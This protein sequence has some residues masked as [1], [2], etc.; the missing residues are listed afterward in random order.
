MHINKLTFTAAM[1][2]TMTLSGVPAL[3]VGA[4]NSHANAQATGAGTQAADHVAA[5]ETRLVDAKLKACQNRETAINNIM[6]RIAT[7]GQKQ[8]DLFTTIAT[9]VETFYTTKGKT[10]SSYDALVAD[11]TAKK[12]AAQTAVDTVKADQANFKCD[13]TDPHG[14]SDTFKADL[15]LEISALKDY[16]TAVKNL[17]V[18]VK[19]VQGTTSSTDKSTTGGSQ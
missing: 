14:A 7:R 2:V 13:G 16:R 3:A 18:G 15:K 9:R 1:V 12:T 19:S 6:A 17:I 10:L 11:V 8:L 4:L 5:A